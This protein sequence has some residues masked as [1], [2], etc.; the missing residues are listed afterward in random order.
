MKK[1][2]YRERYYKV[3]EKEYRSIYEEGT[4][5]KDELLVNDKGKRKIKRTVIKK[6]EEK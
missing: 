4:I 6:K 5:I 3:A 2:V 1:K